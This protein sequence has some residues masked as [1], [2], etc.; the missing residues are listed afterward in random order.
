[1]NLTS[2]RVLFVIGIF[3][4]LNPTFAKTKIYLNSKVYSDQAYTDLYKNQGALVRNIDFQSVHELV[5]QLNQI[6]GLKLADRGEAHITVITPPEYKSELAGFFSIEEIHAQFKNRVQNTTFQIICVGE[7]KGTD[8]K[9]VFYLVI[10]SPDLIALRTELQ[11]QAEARFKAQNKALAASF[12]AKRFWPHI[13]IGFIQ[14]DIHGLS[15]GPE[16]CIND[17]ELV[18]Q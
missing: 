17:L 5:S 1:M 18:I 8:G 7:R 13:T 2:V 12:V 10:D 11:N 3:F 14:D 15:K 6:Y 9:H 16:T 4:L